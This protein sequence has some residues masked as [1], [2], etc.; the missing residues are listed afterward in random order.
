MPE[1]F[2]ARPVGSAVLPCPAGTP[3][4][5]RP[6]HWIA[7]ELVGEDDQPVPW[8][9]FR[10][11]LP[12]GQVESG[13]LDENGVARIEGILSPG[14]CKVSFPQLDKDLWFPA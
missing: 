8:E 1:T 14:Q 9:A 6:I 7:I 13:F 3:D 12:D 10:V 11:V 5:E 4:P 2:S